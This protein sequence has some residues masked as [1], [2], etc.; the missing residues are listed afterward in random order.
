MTAV[1]FT[2]PGQPYGKGRPRVGSVR[3]RARMFTPEKTVSYEN[4]VTVYAQQAMAG[5]ALIESAVDVSLHIVCQI[6]ASWSKKKQ[7]QAEA[8][9]VYP[10]TKPDIDNVEKIV[11]DAINGVVWKDDVQVVDV[12]KTKRYGLVPGVSVRIEVLP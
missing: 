5:R 11:F 6:P 9:T 2:V 12:A 10:T 7:A 1:V 3:G 8:G 4:L